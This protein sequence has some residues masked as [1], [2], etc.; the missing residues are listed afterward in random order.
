LTKW[1]WKILSFDN[2]VWKDV[3]V[4]KYGGESRGS[5]QPGLGML[6]VLR[7]DGGWIFVILTKIQIGLLVQLRRRLVVGTTQSFGLT[8]GWENNRSGIDFHGFM[9]F[10]VR[11]RIQLLVWEDG[12]MLGGFGILSGDG[13]SLNGNNPCTKN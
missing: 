2:E 10:H 4:A 3:V 12:V 8:I 13:N 7:L 11:R 9:A 5:I 6:Q 1:R